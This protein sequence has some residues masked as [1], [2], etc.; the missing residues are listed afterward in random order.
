MF[1]ALFKFQQVLG[2][3]SSILVGFPTSCFQCPQC[4]CRGCNLA[5]GSLSLQVIGSVLLNK[6]SDEFELSLKQLVIDLEAD[7]PH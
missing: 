3:G 6:A 7:L 2:D 5:T 1:S 4:G